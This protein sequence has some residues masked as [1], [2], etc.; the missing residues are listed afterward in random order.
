[1]TDTKLDERAFKREIF[2]RGGQY[3]QCSVEKIG[4]WFI[5]FHESRGHFLSTFG[6]GTVCEAD[7]GGYEVRELLKRESARQQP[8]V[9]L[10][11]WE[12]RPDEH[13]EAIKAAYLA[14][15][16]PALYAK[17][18]EMVSNR[19]SKFAL[20]TL[21]YWLLTHQGGREKGE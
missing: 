18:L 3:L 8:Q 17:A 2:M 16:D 21:V 4:D 1:M 12:D 6:M 9:S 14:P 19:H 20:V 5:C 10:G 13:S 7:A 11:H 15:H